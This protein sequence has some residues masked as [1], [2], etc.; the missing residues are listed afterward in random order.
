MELGWPNGWTRHQRRNSGWSSSC[1]RVWLHLGTT[2]K[3][4]FFKKQIWL[5]TIKDFSRNFVF[6]CGFF[7]SGSRITGRNVVLIFKATQNAVKL[8]R[9]LR[10]NGCKWEKS[11]CGV[12]LF[13]RLR[14]LER[15]LRVQAPQ[16]KKKK[17]R[18]ATH[19]PRLAAQCVL[20]ALMVH[21]RAFP[22]KPISKV[23]R[24]RGERERQRIGGGNC[25]EIPS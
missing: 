15:P 10:A 4:F 22:V 24:G 25:N 6:G 14:Q 13:S 23:G 21:R 16:K 11:K 7:S 5:R 18:W 9:G 8:L 1:V 12:W 2:K 3:D 17:S 19:R 20:V